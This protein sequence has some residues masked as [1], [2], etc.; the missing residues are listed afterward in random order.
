MDTIAW[1]F[2]AFIT[3]AALGAVALH[4]RLREPAGR[5]R[6]L[7]A[8]LRGVA[9]ALL[10]L[11]LF[12][13]VLPAAAGG[14]GDTVLLLDGSLSMRLP[15][16]SGETRWEAARAIVAGTAADRVLRFAGEAVESEA[17]AGVPTG[18]T[19]RLAPAVRAA[20]EA[21]ASR[22]VV[23][24]DG[25]VEDVVEATRVAEGAGLTV[26][27]RSVGEAPA[28]NGGIVEVEAPAW[29]EV[30]EETGIRVAVTGIGRGP[31]TVGLVLRRGDRELA[32]ARVPAPTGGRLSAT[33]LRF[34]PRSP[35]T[36]PVRLDVALEGEDAVPDDDVRSVYLRVAEEPAGVALVSFRPDQEPRFLMPVLERALG[37]P[38]RGW[39]ALPEGRYIR[40]GAGPEAGAVG[41]EAAARRTV[42]EADLVVLHALGPDSPAWARDVAASAAKAL[43]FP[44]AGVE[45]ALPLAPGPERPG[46]WYAAAEIPASPV[47]PLLAGLE[48]GDAPPLRALRVPEPPAGWWG[49]LNARL[50]RRGE[51][52]PVVVAGTVGGRRVAVALGDGYWRWAFADGA[53]REV[54]DRL[55]S[56]LGG[57]LMGEAGGTPF[58]AIAPVSLVV[59]RGE[60]VVFRA[61]AGTDSLRIRIRASGEGADSAV[62]ADS[63]VRVA[64]GEAVAGVLSPGHY[65]WEARLFGPEDATTGSSGSLTVESFSPEFTRPAVSLEEIEGT[66][67]DGVRRRG[68]GRPLR[69]SAWPYVVLVLLLSAE[70]ILRRR[71][72]LR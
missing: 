47:A 31:D 43:I 46:D 20:A 53:G 9:L 71:W 44:A 62:V 41:D 60:P 59:G 12:D 23:V 17:G 18:T 66:V 21:G 65:R 2:Y 40:L 19:S 56:A 51:P 58:E 35:A 57:W 68:S 45:A 10:I 29:A 38:V 27:V 25:G 50:G 16:V 54:Y 14:G 1:A 52:R 36:G 22:V 6:A 72:G 28:W 42:A 24:T 48:P 69:A 26:T 4:Y 32:R 67:G 61:P 33:T 8:G 30:G 11:L 37:V 3:A 70:W 55:W 63:V 13:P 49:P 5:G 34:T 39:M 64:D 15:E 7:L